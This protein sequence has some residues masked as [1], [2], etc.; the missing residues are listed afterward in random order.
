MYFENNSEPD[1]L[2]KIAGV[3]IPIMFDIAFHAKRTPMKLLKIT[4]HW[5]DSSPSF[6]VQ[7]RGAIS[8]II[9]IT[10]VIMLF[11]EL[12]QVMGELRAALRTP[13]TK[14]KQFLGVLQRLDVENFNRFPKEC[15]DFVRETIKTSVFVGNLYQCI[16]GLTI[17]LYSAMPFV[18]G[19]WR[20]TPVRFSYELGQFTGLILSLKCMAFEE[21]KMKLG[22]KLKN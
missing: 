3:P 5:P 9:S 22:L 7:L 21:K 6:S 8:W 13:V 4:G 20:G 19:N 16:C 12:A 14:R 2:L 11:M 10:F 1:L 15:D 17:C 18:G